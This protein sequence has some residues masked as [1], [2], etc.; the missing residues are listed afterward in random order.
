MEAD[1]SQNLQLPYLRPRRVHG[2]GPVQRPG[3]S[4]PRKFKLK[5][6]K[7]NVP[8]PRQSGKRSSL[9]LRGRSAF[10]FYSG[11]QMIV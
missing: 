8:A 5:A 2:V 7:N 4:R 1:K 9:L 10:L 6:G 3:G 11:L